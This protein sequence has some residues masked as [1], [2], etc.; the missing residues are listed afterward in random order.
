LAFPPRGYPSW[1]SHKRIEEKTK[2]KG[3]MKRAKYKS[4]Q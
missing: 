1:G 4:V 2:K 3:G